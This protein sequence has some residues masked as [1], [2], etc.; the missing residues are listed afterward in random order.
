LRLPGPFFRG[1]VGA[2]LIG[3]SGVDTKPMST[4]AVKKSLS[5]TGLALLLLC[6]GGCTSLT[7]PRAGARP[8]QDVASG[9]NVSDDGGPHDNRDVE[10]S[11]VSGLGEILRMFAGRW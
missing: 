3:E 5:M 11:R 10:P 2:S 7:P 8:W 4:H 6:A 9:R 1:V